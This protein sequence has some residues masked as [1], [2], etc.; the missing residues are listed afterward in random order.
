[1]KREKRAK[2]SIVSLKERVEEHKKKLEEAEHEGKIELVSY[3]KDE[4]E[5][6]EKGLE[7]KKRILKNN[8]ILREYSIPFL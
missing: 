2:K 5:N 1:M 4:L 7:K 3:Y 6:F 8:S